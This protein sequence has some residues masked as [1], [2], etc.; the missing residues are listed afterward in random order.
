MIKYKG[1]QV[2]AINYKG[3]D[4]KILKKGNTICWAKSITATVNVEAMRNSG[5][6]GNMVV[7]SSVE[8]TQKVGDVLM[9][10]THNAQSITIPT[11]YNTQVTLQQQDYPTQTESFSVP[12]KATGQTITFNLSKGFP[13]PGT[14]VLTCQWQT[15]YDRTADG[16][17]YA[18]TSSLPANARIDYVK[19]KLEVFVTKSSSTVSISLTYNALNAKLTYYDGW[20]SSQE[21]PFW[22]DIM[23]GDKLALGGG[24]V[25]LGY[26]DFSYY[27]GELCPYDGTTNWAKVIC[28]RKTYYADQNAPMKAISITGLSAGS[29]YTCRGFANAVGTVQSAFAKFSSGSISVSLSADTTLLSVVEGDNTLGTRPVELEADKTFKIGY[30]LPPT[31]TSTNTVVFGTANRYIKITNPN[32]V[33][34]ECTFSWA[35]KNNGFTQS[36]T[37]NLNAHATSA[38]YGNPCYD[39]NDGKT[40]TNDVTVY[41]KKSDGDWASANINQSMSVTETIQCV[42][43]ETT[44][45]S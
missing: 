34:V 10:Y 40:N 18:Q 31:I 14:C 36:A 41:L 24:T 20:I 44:T 12:S 22:S 7:T 43:E 38:Y 4:V 17:F 42:V 19:Q 27:E 26:D 6:A 16:A 2:K 28:N 35:K 21:Y 8:P 3:N 37:V 29:L 25:M 11:Y 39:L 15:L 32:P 30:L 5:I 1:S 33:A 23:D 13:K 9:R 45:T